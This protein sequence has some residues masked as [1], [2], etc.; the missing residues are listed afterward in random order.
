MD[1]ISGSNS[2]NVNRAYGASEGRANNSSVKPTSTEAS[3]VSLTDL[4]ELAD[5][6]DQ[7]AKDVRPEVI[8][9]AKL[10]LDDPNWMSDENIDRMVGKIIQNEDF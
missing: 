10:L 6:V 3:K 7:S 1:P 2:S 8:E 4:G 9:R 5:R